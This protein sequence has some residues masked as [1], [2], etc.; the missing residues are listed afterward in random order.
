MTSSSRINIALIGLGGIAQKAYLP[1]IANHPR[2]NPILCTRNVPTLHQLA[3]QYRIN[4]IYTNVA[5]LMQTKIDAAM[6]HSATE[7]HFPIVSKLLNAGIPV[8]V[9]KPLSYSIQESEELLNIADQKRILLYVGFN[10]RFAPLIQA[11]THQ[12]D[13][14]HI[15][16]QK[17][18]VHLPDNPRVFIMDDFIHVIDSLRYLGQGKVKNL[19]VFSRLRDDEMLE[20][21]QVQ[22]QQN[23]TLLTGIMNRISGITEE[24]VEYYS[25]E[26]KW[27]IENLSSG[28]HYEKEHKNVLAFGNWESTLYKRGFVHMI[29]DWLNVLQNNT[30][31]SSRIQDIWETHHLCESILKLINENNALDEVI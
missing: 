5:D 27:L 30:F 26:N 9:D 17:N 31:D 7:S 3:N 21:I 13:P 23:N 19:Q 11:L 20:S 10:R 4:S 25:P 6:I 15:I 22:W 14:I 18:R 1:I 29:E 28:W 8:F 2:I 16:W 24:R 12:S